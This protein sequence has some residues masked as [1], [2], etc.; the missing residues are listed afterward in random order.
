M[1]VLKFESV[2][3]KNKVNTFIVRVHKNKPIHVTVY[4]HSAFIFPFFEPI[5]YDST[6]PYILGKIPPFVASFFHLC[7]VCFLPLQTL[8]SMDALTSKHTELYN[9]AKISFLHMFHFN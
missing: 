6:L 4:L 7:H 8:T 1:F 9:F 5:S 3:F 2:S